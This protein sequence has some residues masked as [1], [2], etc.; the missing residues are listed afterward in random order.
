MALN[1]VAPAEGSKHNECGY[2]AKKHQDEG[3]EAFFRFRPIAFVEYHKREADKRHSAK[4]HRDYYTDLVRTA[5]MRIPIRR[6]LIVAGGAA[7]GCAFAYLLWEWFND[8]V[9]ANTVIAIFTVVM[10]V[11]TYF[12]WVAARGQLAHMR[13]ERRPWLQIVDPY[14]RDINSNEPLEFEFTIVN[15]GQTPATVD[16]IDFGV[17]GVSPNLSIQK[18]REGMAAD[19]PHQFPTVAIVAPQSEVLQTWSLKTLGSSEESDI[20]N[21]RR[22]ILVAAILHYCGPT[23]ERFETASLLEWHRQDR[24]MSYTGTSEE[25]YMR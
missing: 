1:P 10:G 14:I 5:C 7:L 6:T 19:P 21:R 13:E 4:E 9:E 2:D 11:T 17:W 12:Q 18:I 24:P 22:T 16:R 20:H 8:R 15:K 25:N 23:R 3:Y